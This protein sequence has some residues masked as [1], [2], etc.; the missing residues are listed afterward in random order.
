MRSGR[1]SVKYQPYSHCVRAGMS[2][3][4]TAEA[5]AENGH[6]QSEEGKWKQTLTKVLRR[7]H[8]EPDGGTMGRDETSSCDSLSGSWQWLFVG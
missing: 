8:G 4:T 7:S 3:P 1:E 2:R 5:V 6:I